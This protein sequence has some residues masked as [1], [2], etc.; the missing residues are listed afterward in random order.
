[1]KKATR[2]LLL[3]AAMLFLS[4]SARS[5]QQ[6]YKTGEVI[7]KLKDKSH[8]LHNRSNVSRYAAVQT[9][10]KQINDVFLQLRVREAEPLMPLITLNSTANNRRSF[11]GRKDLSQLYLLRF[12]STAVASMEYAVAALRQLD[13]VEYAEPNYIRKIQ[14]VD[15]TQASHYTSQWYLPAIGMPTLWEKPI[16]NKKRPVIAIL[17]TGIDATN[18]NIAPNLWVNPNEDGDN[19][20]N[21][22]NGFI[23]DFNGWDFINNRNY[24]YDD[25]GHGT[26]C[27]GLA[28]AVA[29]GNEGISGANPNALL[30]ILKV[31]DS[32]GYGDDATVI[33]GIN[34]AVANGADIISMSFGDYNPSQALQDALEEASHQVLLFASAG[35]EHKGIDEPSFPAAYPFVIGVEATDEQGELASFSNY[36]DD[37]RFSEG[38]NYDVRAPGVNM[39]STYPTFGALRGIGY[40]RLDGTSMACPLVAGAVSRL[41]Q[42]RNFNSLGELRDILV[43]TCGSTIDMAAAYAAT[44]ETLNDEIFQCDING[45]MMTFQK[46]S[47]TTA[48]VGNG[49]SPAISSDTG[50]SIHIPNDVHG[51]LVTS[52]AENAFGGCGKITEVVLP[53]HISNIGAQAFSGCSLLNHLLILSAD[54]PSCAS[55]AFDALAYTSC[56]VE[57][58]KGSEGNYLV[59][60]PWSNFAANLQSLGYDN[61]EYIAKTIGDYSFSAQVVDSQKKLVMLYGVDPLTDDV[62]GIVEVPEYIDGY[63]VTSLRSSLFLQR[64][65]LKQVVLPDCITKIPGQAFGSCHNLETVNYPSSLKSIGDYAFRDC[66][67]FKNGHIPGN[68]KTIGGSAFENS[69]IESLFLD[70]GVERLEL[71]A[72]NHCLSLKTIQLPSTVCSIFEAFEDLP[73]VESIAVAQGNLFYDSRYNCNA[74]ISSKENYLLRGCKNTVIPDD[75]TKIGGFWGTKGLTELHLSKHVDFISPDGLRGLE[76]LNS[77]TVDKHNQRY[78][79]PSGS[80]VVLEAGEIEV[81]CSNSVI[82]EDA[83]TIKALSAYRSPHIT[84]ITIP[85]AMNIDFLTFGGCPITSVIS[86]A[87]RPVAISD[88]AFYDSYYGWYETDNRT[89]DAIYSSSTLYVP[90]GTKD[91]YMNTAGW[92]NFENIVELPSVLRGDTDNNGT[93]DEAD[94]FTLIHHLLHKD[95]D[96]YHP[97][98]A[99]ADEDGRITSR[100]LISLHALLSGQSLENNTEHFDSDFILYASNLNPGERN[101]ISVHVQEYSD[102]TETE[103]LFAYIRLPEGMTFAE[104]PITFNENFGDDY[105]KDYSIED[106]IIR[107]IICPATKSARNSLPYYP[108][109]SICV[110]SVDVEDKINSEGDFI[111]YSTLVSHDGKINENHGFQKYAISEPQNQLNKGDVNGDSDVDIADAVCIVNYVVSKPNTSFNEAAADVNGDGDIDIADAVH[112]VNLVVGKIPALVPHFSW[113]LP[114]PE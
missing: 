87:K 40:K 64:E 90:Y 38:Y 44:S 101:E 77:V 50:G 81:L 52:V 45:V 6:R 79:S 47:V 110:L 43:R 9:S 98:A 39:L 93:L 86:L 21:D 80:N 106:N 62:N 111:S 59:V 27:A 17:D 108:G 57:V 94:Y 112:I 48:Q 51:L 1:M 75:V 53:C 61:G 31:M 102:N 5:Q 26:H 3:I 34:Y 29:V 11:T 41:M 49:T 113:T 33:N 85:T 7:V 60:A 109:S 56:L 8:V 68:V 25:N 71:N 12:D 84:S 105:V 66:L 15:Y 4:L 63:R 2:Y 10:N 70:E 88:M 100:D 24:L 32:S 99:D 37:G 89:E 73:N 74:I 16:I 54:A 46:T 107:I 65:W 76:D 42:C 22:G 104:K 13:D 36:D 58:P 69:G 78:Y 14:S 72:F 28:A 95:I 35:N 83:T 55:N 96:S 67:A 20:D 19:E 103:A 23:D 82:P 114:E 91:I 30:M 97:T 92:S 18:P